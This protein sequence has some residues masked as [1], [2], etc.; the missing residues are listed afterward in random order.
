M[1]TSYQELKKELLDDP[2]INEAYQDSEGEYQAMRAVYLARAEQGITQ[3]ELSAITHIP[4]KT[5]SKI[6]TGSTNV[7]VKTLSKIAKGL[8]KQLRIEIV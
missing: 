8:G 5:I 3:K 2:K 7:T 6:E 1:R 4:Q